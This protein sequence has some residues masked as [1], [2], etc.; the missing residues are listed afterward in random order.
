MRIIIIILLSVCFIRGDAELSV[1]KPVNQNLDE[2]PAG[3]NESKEPETVNIDGNVGLQVIEGSSSSANTNTT[4]DSDIIWH[5]DFET[6]DFSQW[7]EWHKGWNSGDWAMATATSPV[8]SGSYSGKLT[9]DT[10]K[11]KSAVR[12]PV[13]RVHGLTELLPDEAYMSVWYYFT[14]NL[15]SRSWWNIW[16]WK[17]GFFKD[18]P[19]NKRGTSKPVYSIYLKNDGQ[20][21]YYFQMGDKIG[22][23]CIY[24]NSGY[25]TIA[26]SPIKFDPNTWVH[27]ECFYRWSNQS[28]GQ[29]T[30]WQ[31]GV[32]IWD[33]EDVYTMHCFEPD[34]YSRLYKQW[35]I[36]H[37]SSNLVPDSIS[38]Y[39]DD[40]AVSIPR[41]GPTCSTTDR[42]K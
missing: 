42:M 36:N 13:R 32:Q 10:S 24:K 3:L 23:D 30:C 1:A 12:L 7:R 34:E 26:K 27:L 38:I 5:A 22:P 11:V 41:L 37:Y 19:T 18:Y 33:V 14:E 9:I 39:I 8:H 21:H 16:D 29:I 35:K 31:N 6:G 20:G 25:G 17:T 15:D 4:C 40:A 2:S 28:D